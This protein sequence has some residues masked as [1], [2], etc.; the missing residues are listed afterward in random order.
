MNITEALRILQAAPANAPGFPV[1]LACGFTP[2]HLQTFLGACLQRAIPDR[3][4]G[5]DSGLF[6]DLAGT[7]ESLAGKP[8]PAVAIA[9]EWADLDSR[10][11]YRQLGGWGP[12]DV[13][14]IVAGASKAF[15]RLARAIERIPAGARV[16]IS[17]PT[18]P[19]PPAF[20]T[21]RWQSSGAELEL[22]YALAA[23]A[24]QMGMQANVFVVNQERFAEASP[25]AGRFDLK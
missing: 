16:G 21:A 20:S 15:E 25:P 3:A 1:T 18:L 22:R 14:R 10:L 23:F 11:G 13:A 19:L 7:L 12:A 5:I 2:L 6:G 8:A 4:V 9:L 24:R 17:L